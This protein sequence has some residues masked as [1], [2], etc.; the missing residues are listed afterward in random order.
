[1]QHSN[2][3]FHGLSSPCICLLVTKG[4]THMSP[5]EKSSRRRGPSRRHEALWCGPPASP[6]RGF[7]RRGAVSAP[8]LQGL[9][10]AKAFHYPR[11]V[12]GWPWPNGHMPRSSRCP[13]PGVRSPPLR[14]GASQGER[15]LRGK[16]G[17]NIE[18]GF[19]GGTHSVRPRGTAER[20]PRHFFPATCVEDC[21]GAYRPHAS[22]KPVPSSGRAE[23]VPPRG[24]PS[25]LGWPCGG[26]PGDNA[27]GGFL[28]GAR[29]PRPDCKAELAPWH[30]IPTRWGGREAGGLPGVCLAE[31]RAILAGVRRPPL[32]EVGYPS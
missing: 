27:G 5:G 30:S 31:T 16:P 4:A 2:R 22:V 1:M 6:Q 25:E 9:T 20:L 32:H 3:K 24:G 18:G 29:S 8:G 15:A 17:D 23:A 19:L 26:K 13:P 28:G 10:H 14:G 11:W 12:A 7:S 21:A